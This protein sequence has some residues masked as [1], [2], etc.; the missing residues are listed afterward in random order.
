MSNLTEINLI[1]FMDIDKSMVR[2]YL[3]LY[4]LKYKATDGNANLKP[5][6]KM[7]DVFQVEPEVIDSTNITDSLQN[8][9]GLL[10]NAISSIFSAENEQE[11]KA[12]K[13][14]QKDKKQVK[15]EKEGFYF[16]LPIFEDKLE[17]DYNFRWSSF[18]G[19]QRASSDKLK[20]SLAEG[21]VKGLVSG[22][23]GSLLKNVL[24]A[25]KGSGSGFNFSS[26]GQ[27]VGSFISSQ[28]TQKALQQNLGTTFVSGDKQIFDGTDFR[29]YSYA[30]D[31]IVPKDKDSHLLILNSLTLIKNLIMPVQGRAT[32]LT[33]SILS[34]IENGINDQ[35]VINKIQ[36]K[37][38]QAQ[39]QLKSK[40][41]G[42]D[43]ALNTF[44]EGSSLNFYTMTY[45]SV[46]TGVITTLKDTDDQGN[47]IEPNIIKFFIA[48]AVTNFKTNVSLEQGFFDETNLPSVNGFSMNFTELIPFHSETVNAVEISDT[49]DIDANPDNEIYKKISIL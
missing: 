16:K 21:V 40:A 38:A 19:G 30:L 45:P 10:S 23:S 47:V 14:T 3:Y 4:P 2:A 46:F 1:D 39:Q 9:S 32:D 33:R 48:S 44:K 5:N 26:L 29:T 13:T 12:K 11:E 28:E 35:G 31:N 20:A 17:N 7:E 15:V 6:L 43:D 22:A 41:K 24:G 49:T 27:G 18:K 34:K 42:L 36:N 8:I 25:G 37:T